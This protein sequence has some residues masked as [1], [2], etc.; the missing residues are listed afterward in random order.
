MPGLVS[1]A[2]WQVGNAERQVLRW[3]VTM[4]AD[5]RERGSCL[6]PVTLVD[7]AVDRCR[8]WAGFRVR[9]GNAATLAVKGLAPLKTTILWSAEWYAELVFHAPLHWSVLDHLRGVYPATGA[10]EAAGLAETLD[11]LSAAHGV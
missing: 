3:P 8:L 9:P 1:K 6:L 11:R 4:P 2:D 5:I 7:L 10:D